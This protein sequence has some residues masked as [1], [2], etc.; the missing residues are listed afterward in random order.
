MVQRT[1]LFPLM[2]TRSLP[3]RQMPFLNLDDLS[4]RRL[5]TARIL[6]IEPDE[7]KRRLLC[8]LLRSAGMSNLLTCPSAEDSFEALRMFDP[9]LV[10]LEWELPGMS[11]VELTRAIRRAALAPD[12]RIHNA[13]VP[14]IMLTARRRERDVVEARNAG[15]DEF[16]IRPFSM[17]SLNRSLS[18]VLLRRRAFVVSEAYVGPER[19]RQRKAAPFKGPLKREDDIEAVAEVVVEENTRQEIS[20][21]LISL[22]ALM[23]A[24]GGEVHGPTLTHIIRRLINAGRQAQEMRLSLIAQATQSLQAYCEIFGDAADP[25]VVDVHLEALI[26]LSDLPVDKLEECRDQ[27]NRIVRDLNI[28][29]RKRQR[30][31]Q[32]ASV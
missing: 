22:K 28:L 18:A 14:I 31:T 3:M 8:E 4:Q 29:V 20:I 2:F 24:R 15:I 9:D 21:E 5:G 16:V 7:G 17:A 6:V 12:E 11:G 26:S 25:E 32:K 1:P 10:V 30:Q 27:G 13:R 19:R 23:Q